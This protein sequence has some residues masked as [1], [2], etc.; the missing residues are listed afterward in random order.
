[1]FAKRYSDDL[2]VYIRCTDGRKL[3]HNVNV[4]YLFAPIQ[5]PDDSID[6]FGV[7]I[8]VRIL[9]VYNVNDELMVAAGN[10]IVNLFAHMDSIESFTISEL[11]SPFIK[12]KRFKYYI[13]AKEIYKTLFLHEKYGCKFAILVDR[14]N[15]EIK[16]KKNSLLAFEP[17][18]EM[19]VDFLNSIPKNCFSDE[20]A[21]LDV[22]EKA[23]LLYDEIY[24]RSLLE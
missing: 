6:L 3:G 17:C 21:T 10:K 8:I 1:M 24:N 18:F 11:N 9:S 4:D 7:G 2:A 15:N 13:R 16:C 14:I 23:R 12:T 22:T 19:C 5:P 20:I